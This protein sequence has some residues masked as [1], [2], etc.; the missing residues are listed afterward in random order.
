MRRRLSTTDNLPGPPEPDRLQFVMTIHTTLSISCR[1]NLSRHKMVKDFGTIK[2]RDTLN[3]SLKLNSAQKTVLSFLFYEPP[4]PASDAA[5][6]S[7]RWATLTTKHV[8]A[9]DDYDRAVSELFDRDLICKIDDQSLELINEYFASDP[10]HGPLNGMPPKG[11]LQYSIRYAHTLECYLNEHGDGFD[12]TWAYD[13]LTDERQIV[14]GTT[15]LNCME[16]L[17][18]QLSSEDEEWKTISK[19]AGPFE[20]GPWR[21]DWW[22]KYSHGFKIEIIRTPG[23]A[24]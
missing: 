17:R 22:S 6:N 19:I 18:D 21:L 9:I 24:R 7:R 1:G 11:S 14:Y 3:A 12:R 10:A 23:I 4:R 2:L 16:F 13:V 20:C 5:K 8:L 15:H